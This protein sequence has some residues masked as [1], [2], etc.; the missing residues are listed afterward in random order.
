MMEK[1]K[2]KSGKDA[3]KDQKAIQKLRREVERA[4]RTLS[5]S[6]EAKLEID[7]LFAGKD[8][9]ETL[10][11]AKFEELCSD[12]FKKTLEPV[13]K[14]VA[15]SG[16]PAKKIDEIVLVGGSTR[17]PKVQE[18]LSKYFGGKELNKSINPDEAVAY[19]AAVQGGILSG[20][21]GEETKDLLLLDVAP[22]TLGIET[23]GGV[24]NKIIPRNHVVPTKK[25]QIFSTAADYQP[26]VEIQVYEGERA[27]TKDC[28]RLGKFEIHVPPVPRGV[29]QIEVTFEVD[30]NGVLSVSATDIGTGKGNKIE[31]TNDKGRLSPEEVKRMI[32]RVEA[33]TS[34]E[35]YVFSM[36]KTLSDSGSMSI[37]KREKMKVE[38]VLDKASQWLDDNT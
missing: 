15:D 37:N 24:M 27:M 11:R 13:K 23:V 4:K 32:A 29:P 36:K 3:S 14:V 12:L 22:L 18:L 9:S 5:G 6:N 16:I 30:A 25:S 20:K 17:I 7:G 19:G 38:A 21:G 26:V 31:I 33:R 8:F 10:T 2:A 34:L 35:N 1:F 28:H